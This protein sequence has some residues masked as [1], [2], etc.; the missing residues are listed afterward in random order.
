M[1]SMRQAALY[2]FPSLHNHFDF[3]FCPSMGLIEF[4]FKVVGIM[5]HLLLKWW[6][7]Y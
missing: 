4:E 2:D 6:L 1:T 7:H 3:D 5:A